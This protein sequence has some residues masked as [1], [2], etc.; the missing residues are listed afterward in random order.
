MRSVVTSFYN[1]CLKF[2]YSLLVI[3]KAYVFSQSFLIFL[4]RYRWQLRIIK[5]NTKTTAK[6]YKKNNEKITFS[7]IRCSFLIKTSN[8]NNLWCSIL[9]EFC[10][11]IPHFNWC[12]LSLTPPFG[13]GDH[14]WI[15]RWGLKQ[16]CIF[17]DFFHHF[18]LPLS[19]PNRFNLL[20]F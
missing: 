2:K 18:H 5:N 20:Q 7:R 1:E 9:R 12:I 16:G 14:L 17:C 15:N 10:W 8:R 4:Y 11:I 19:S 3:L 13:G 6:D